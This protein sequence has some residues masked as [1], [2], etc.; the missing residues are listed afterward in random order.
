MPTPTA[1]GGSGVN[2]TVTDV[3]W[4][5][6]QSYIM[7][8]AGHN[9]IHAG[10]VSPGGD[11]S[12]STVEMEDNAMMDISEQQIQQNQHPGHYPAF[13]KRV[14]VNNA[15]RGQMYDASRHLDESSIVA[16][17][18]SNGVV[19]AWHQS[20]LLENSNISK[21]PT[22][23]AQSGLFHGRNR[24]RAASTS[25]AFGQPE[26]V[27]LAHS[28]AVNRLAWH[29]TGNRP[30]LLL[31]ASQDG[32]VKLWDRRASSPMLSDV[33]VE[34]PPVRASS[35]K[36]WFGFGGAQVATESKSSMASA[37]LPTSN[38]HCVSTYTPKC[39]AVRLLIMYY[40][41]PQSFAVTDPYLLHSIHLSTFRLEISSGTLLS[42]MS[43]HWLVIMALYVYTM[44]G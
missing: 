9:T 42:R 1:G 15:A 16:A 24:E 10:G 30:Y 8:D 41:I 20:S 18:G 6:P 37:N 40:F 28:R 2:V 4:S 21:S 32:T 12:S 7:A 31:T 36:T 19:V 5:L 35:V 43:L 34:V 25:A 13:I 23:N 3:A 38:W 27:F 33:K 29:P 44:F 22:N 11:T 17:A 14:R 26:A 39:E